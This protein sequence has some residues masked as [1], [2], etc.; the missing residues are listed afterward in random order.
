MPLGASRSTRLGA[1]LPSPFTGSE[2]PS[3]TSTTSP[4]A[5]RPLETTQ[6][7][8]Y[9]SG[10]PALS[11][12]YYGSGYD[13][14]G[15]RSLLPP[16]PSLPRPYSYTH[17]MSQ[18]SQMQPWSYA[19]TRQMRGPDA[20]RDDRDREIARR[21]LL[22][23]VASMEGDPR[24]PTWEPAPTPGRGAAAA[25]DP[26]SAPEPK[27]SRERSAITSGRGTG[28]G[29][30]VGGEAVPSS[31]S[32][33][34]ESEKRSSLLPA[35]GGADPYIRRGE[36]GVPSAPLPSMQPPPRLVPPE[37]YT[38]S[39]RA[40]S[41]LLSP[42]LAGVDVSRRRSSDPTFRRES[43]WQQQQQQQQLEARARLESSVGW[44]ERGSGVRSS[45]F[46]STGRWTEERRLSAPAT[47]YHRPEQLAE[48]RHHHEQLSRYRSFYAS[49]AT[50]VE[51][52]P[53]RLGSRSTLLPP[54]EAYGG[55]SPTSQSLAV[56]A[57]DL[58]QTLYPRFPGLMTG[59]GSAARSVRGG[60]AS[61]LGRQPL[62]SV[63][64]VSP[65]WRSEPMGRRDQRR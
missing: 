47:M 7:R 36:S 8:R 20:Q 64:A 65:R 23:G 62:P 12:H 37:A 2:V 34:G 49:E 55:I 32:F 26:F 43:T 19:G 51:L 50:P 16:S 13:E 48:E 39:S 22:R 45:T 1:I 56:G 41:P 10:D 52:T 59:P 6:H 27:R 21:S 4:A 3:P 25:V 18:P 30:R 11:R 54:P 31:F 9:V 29:S 15:R 24:G 60:G 44:E 58:S 61:T 63:E 33:R 28:S 35:T 17:S 5:V 40:P 38:P 57:E 46:P 53:P 42:T 14:E